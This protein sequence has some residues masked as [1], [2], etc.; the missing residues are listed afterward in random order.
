MRGKFSSV[1]REPGLHLHFTGRKPEGRIYLQRGRVFQR[2]KELKLEKGSLR[3]QR[4]WQ[5][6]GSCRG[7]R[8]LKGRREGVVERKGR[9]LEGGS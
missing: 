5:E 4:R 6:E 8:E 1:R 2:E 7:R 9:R 3:E